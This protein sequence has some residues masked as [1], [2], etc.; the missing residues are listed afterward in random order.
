MA[1]QGRREQVTVRTRRRHMAPS[2]VPR[3]V[4]TATGTPPVAAAWWWC[5]LLLHGVIVISDG[6]SS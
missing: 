1:P 2:D 6:I 4:R 5:F 3:R